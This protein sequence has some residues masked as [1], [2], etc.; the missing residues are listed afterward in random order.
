MI[1]QQIPESE[2]KEAVSE[3]FEHHADLKTIVTPE[4]DMRQIEELLGAKPNFFPTPYVV[5]STSS[6][7]QMCS[8]ENNFLDVVATAL[9]VH[10]AEFLL[11]VF[12]G[13]YGHIINRAPSQNCICYACSTPLRVTK[14]SAPLRPAQEDASDPR[15]FYP[16]YSYTPVTWE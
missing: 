2:W 15:Y 16:V 1:P 3:F 6:C 4:K 5:K 13:K 7:C 9:Q 10:T 8:R 11:G 12:Q 14:F